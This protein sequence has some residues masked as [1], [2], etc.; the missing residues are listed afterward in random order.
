L[1]GWVA[2]AAELSRYREFDL[3]S[4]VAAVTAVTQS[5]E[6]DMK[7]IHSRPALLQEVVWQPR[8]MSGAPKADRNSINEI[9]FSFVDDQLFKM[10]VSYDR[11]RTAGLT[12][13]DMIAA[14][15]ELYGVPAQTRTSADLVD[16]GVVLAEWEQADTHVTLRR[17]QYSESFS[18][19]IGSVSLET[20]ARK[21]RATAL[22]IDAREAPVREAALAKKRADELR[23]AEE[24]TRTTNKKIFKP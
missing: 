7:T 2:S 21:A 9:V 22:V 16:G 4:S 15:T 12:N 5:A 19:V 13:A 18:L 23:Q 10:T 20:S 8:Y 11:S 6:R 24:Q 1:A 17:S 3:G 14:I